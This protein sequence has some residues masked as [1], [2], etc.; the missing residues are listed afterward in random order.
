MRNAVVTIYRQSLRNPKI[1]K[2]SQTCSPARQTVCYVKLMRNMSIS[3]FVFGHLPWRIWRTLGSAPCGPGSSP[4]P[5][6]SCRCRP[7]GPSPT[8]AGDVRCWPKGTV[9][10]SCLAR[11]GSPRRSCR[12]GCC[13]AQVS[14]CSPVD[15]RAGSKQD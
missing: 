1:I 14:D 9:A 4:N 7:S 3:L 5:L 13:S 15:E 10:G 11:A 2:S 8:R 6:N 12:S